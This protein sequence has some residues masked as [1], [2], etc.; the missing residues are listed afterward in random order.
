MVNDFP[1]PSH[2]QDWTKGESAERV[3]TVKKVVGFP[4]PSAERVHCKKV[5]SRTEC[6]ES[7]L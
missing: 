2:S 6:R 5:I 7:T 1:V 4:A 3:Y